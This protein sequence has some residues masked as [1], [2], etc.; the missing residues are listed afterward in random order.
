MIRVES[1]LMKE[2]LN[3]LSST[4]WWLS[5]MVAGIVASVLASYFRNIIDAIL[6]RLSTR[7][8]KK[9]QRQSLE[10]AVTIEKIQSD[11]NEEILF[12]LEIQNHKLNGILAVVCS[13]FCFSLY[14]FRHMDSSQSMTG[15]EPTFRL[16]L[17][18]LSMIF[19]F[20]SMQAFSSA[21]DK[22]AILREARRNRQL[23]GYPAST[24]SS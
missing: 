12:S 3:N 16:I 21:V 5:V 17:L 18:I 8:K 7:W 13:I 6:S 24:E 15:I 4:S 22:S 1:A 14:Y 23:K 10:K 19:P 11:V 2:F 9:S 20:I